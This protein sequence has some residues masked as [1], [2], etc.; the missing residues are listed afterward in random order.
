MASFPVPSVRNTIEPAAMHLKAIA[1]GL[2]FGL[3]A[4]AIR[5][6]RP[7]AAQL[8][9][10]VCCCR[11][12]FSRLAK[13]IMS[14]SCEATHGVSPSAPTRILLY[15]IQRTTCLSPS[16]SS[17]MTPGMS[18]TPM[19]PST[20]GTGSMPLIINPVVLSLSSCL[21]R[22]AVS[23]VCHSFKRVLSPKL[24]RPRTAWALS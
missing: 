14:R 13:L 3:Q 15:S 19:I 11:V 4:S 17:I 2:L 9:K 16:T 23:T 20:C 1:T 21:A 10:E 5:V 8:K 18:L 6:G 24:P 12:R 22:L 7:S